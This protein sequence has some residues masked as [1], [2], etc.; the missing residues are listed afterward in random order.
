MVIRTPSRSPVSRIFARSA[1][2]PETSASS[3]SKAWG[4][5]VLAATIF[6]AI[7]RRLPLKGIRSSDADSAGMPAGAFGPAARRT[8]SSVIRPPGPLPRTAPSSTPRSFASFRT[9]G[10]ARTSPP[11]PAAF[12]RSPVRVHRF[13][14]CGGRAIGRRHGVR[15]RPARRGLDEGDRLPHLHDLSGLRKDLQEGPG[16]RRGK[17][18]VRLVGQDLDQQVV[19]LDRGPFGHQP[20]DDLPFRDPLPHVGEFQLDRHGL[21]SPFRT[22]PR[23]WEMIFRNLDGG[24]KIQEAFHA[25]DRFN[26]RHRACRPPGIFP[27]DAAGNGYR[28][29]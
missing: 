17:L 23:L 25:T 12:P 8:S 4:T 15:A 29:S 24:A 9:T 18:D 27:P 20:A 2:R 19:L 13:A 14:G 7:I 16:H 10:V 11:A 21:R 22:R 5:R 3:T 28:P 1:R 26:R 6:R